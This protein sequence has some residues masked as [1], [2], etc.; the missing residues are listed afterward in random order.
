MSDIKL[1][2][3]DDEEDFVRTLAERLELRDLASNTALDGQQAISVVDGCEP[4]VMILDLKM[5]GI[6]GMEVLRRVRS[7]YPK[8][9]VI[10]QTGHGNDLDESEARRLGVFDY[11]KKPVD[12]ELLVDR[13][14][15][16]AQAKKKIGSMSAAAFAEAGEHDTARELMKK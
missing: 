4:D 8:I 15:A 7:K 3:V 9:Q 13:I 12:I 2:L 16:A 5:P 1:L 11:L 14:R 10:I 6:D